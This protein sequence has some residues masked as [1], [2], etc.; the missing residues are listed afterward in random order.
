MHKGNI[1][2]LPKDAS[3][4]GVVQMLQERFARSS[5]SG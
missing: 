2:S 4:K 3:R 1:V 5:E